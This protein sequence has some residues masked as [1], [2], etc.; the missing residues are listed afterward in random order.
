MTDIF[1]E[2]EQDLRHERLKKLWDRFGLYVIVA[3]VVVV[4]VTAGWRGWVAWKEHQA[5]AS[6]DVMLAAL[7]TA[8]AGDHKK[9]AVELGD[10]AG[11]AGVGYQVLARFRAATELAQSGDE[12]GAVSALDAIAA[13]GAVPLLYRNLAHIR[14]GYLVLDD[15]DR[16]AVESRVSSLAE[17]DNA[18][19]QSAR[20]LMGVAAYQA[21]DYAG[22]RKWFQAI[23][24]D[25]N[26][27]A[28]ATDRAR[29]MLALVNGALA[30]AA[31]APKP[32]N[33]S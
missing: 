17:T 15:G 23:V 33:P 29:I 7:K 30:P 18:W 31:S 1:H 25:P 13:D 26:G 20:E 2:V 10:L 32:A 16:K 5:A 21:G 28:D 3:A 14:A 24:E 27:P 19:R 8:E 11:K 9:A 22:A 4:A 12:T 6:G